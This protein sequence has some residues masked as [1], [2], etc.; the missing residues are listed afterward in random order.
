MRALAHNISQVTVEHYLNHY[1]ISSPVVKKIVS[2]IMAKV[3]N[4]T[5]SDT[6]TYIVESKIIMFVLG[7]LSGFPLNSLWKY[8]ST[9]FKSVANGVRPPGG[10]VVGSGP[11]AL[12]S[13][14]APERRSSFGSLNTV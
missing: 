11:S 10:N 14:L 12:P 6:F 4:S 9:K 8:L 3:V 1:N 5:N 2:S 13:Y 7:L